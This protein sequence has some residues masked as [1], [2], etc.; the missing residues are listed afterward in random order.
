MLIS[1]AELAD[2][3]LLLVG[4]T[5]EDGLAWIMIRTWLD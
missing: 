2:D 5:E 1:T 4:R 3:F